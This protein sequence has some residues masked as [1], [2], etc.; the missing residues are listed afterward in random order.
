AAVVRAVQEDALQRRVLRRRVRVA[1]AQQVGGPDRAGLEVPAARGAF[2]RAA[3]GDGRVQPLTPHLRRIPSLLP[4]HR[5]LYLTGLPFVAISIG[6]GLA[7]PQV[8]RLVID[9]GVQGGRIE[10]LNQMALLLVGILL[11]EAVATF[12]RDYCF[13]LGAE[14]TTAR[15]RQAVFETLLRQD[16]Q[17]FDRRDTGE[18]TTRLWADIPHL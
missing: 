7:Y 15:L 2:R 11:V 3:E 16:V 4:P 18:I 6:T 13:N 12:V 5:P 1:L 17:F 14:R 9:E 8:I 10:R